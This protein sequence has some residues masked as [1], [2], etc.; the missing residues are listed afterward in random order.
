MKR[1]KL[2]RWIIV[3]G[4]VTAGF[5]LYV[6]LV[7]VNAKN[8]TGRQKIVKA[9][10]P[11]L[12][13][14]GK[15][16]GKKTKMKINQAAAS[17]LVSFYS[18]KTTT[19]SGGEIQFDSFRGKKVMIVNT[20]SDCGF[21]PQYEDLQKLYEKFQG[22]LVILGFPANDFGEQ[23]KGSDQQIATFCKLNYGLRFPLATKSQVIRGVSQ[24][25]VFEW[26]S[27]SRENGW[28]DQQP[29]WNFSKYLVN[30]QGVLTHYFDPS[31][32]PLS[33]EVLSA[34]KP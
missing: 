29:T 31:V 12:M 19:N 11:V 34:L 7:N 27:N 18:L 16:F 24:N 10:Y 9:F 26:L 4:L 25:K 3:L 2:I 28:N 17:P 22:N 32:S 1:R 33:P 21:T 30:E 15:L 20:A 14:V 23:E 5:L 6:E 8:M 13:N